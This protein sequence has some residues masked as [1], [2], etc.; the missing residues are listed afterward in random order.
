MLSQFQALNPP[1]APPAQQ[2]SNESQQGPPAAGSLDSI[3]LGQ[4]KSMV[5]AVPKPKVRSIF[6]S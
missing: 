5:N 3:T 2:P 1:A 4:L 6:C